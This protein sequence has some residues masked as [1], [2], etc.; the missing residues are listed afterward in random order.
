MASVFQKWRDTLLKFKKKKLFRP[1]WEVLLQGLSQHRK[2]SRG[3]T[4]VQNICHQAQL[5]RGLWTIFFLGVCS[6]EIDFSRLDISYLW[7]FSAPILLLCL[8]SCILRQLL[9][10]H[11]TQSTFVVL[12]LSFTALPVSSDLGNEIFVTRNPLLFYEAPFLFYPIASSA[13]R[14]PPC[15]ALL[16]CL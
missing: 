8:L 5:G 16:F 10:I 12:N 11:G 9:T 15:S 14:P 13:A 2:L 7:S 1:S 3:P 6:F 4:V